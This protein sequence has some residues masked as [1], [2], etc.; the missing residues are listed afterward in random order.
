[1]AKKTQLPKISKEIVETLP[2]KNY[3]AASIIVN[4][5]LIAVSLLITKWMPPKIPLYYG[6][7]QSNAQLAPNWLLII[8]SSLSLLIIGVNIV[9]AINAKNEFL[10]KTFILASVAATFFSGITTL[11]IIFLV[12]SF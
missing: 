5:V 7:P 9:L 10:K 6:L 8:P 2:F 4:L 1:M 12:S 3:L 11:K